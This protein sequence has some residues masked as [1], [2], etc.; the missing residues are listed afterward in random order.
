M[1]KIRIPTVF[2]KP[3]S[4]VIE[5]AYRFVFSNF[6]IHQPQ[7][8]TPARIRYT[9]LNRTF[10]CNKAVEELGYKPI[11]TLQVLT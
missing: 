6:G 5:W 8:L 11:V 10:I 1:P 9:T 7:I 4:Y 2:I 3:A